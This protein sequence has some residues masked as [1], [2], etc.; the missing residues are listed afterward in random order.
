MTNKS[1]QKLVCVPVLITSAINVSAANTVLTDATVRLDL[2][3]KSI[4]QWRSTP[5]VSHVIVCDGS[6][7][8]FNP[9][10]SNLTSTQGRVGCEVLAFTNDI[11]GVKA[12][13]KGYGEGEIVNHALQQSSVLKDSSHF[14]KCTGKLWIE[15]FSIC[16]KGFNG[17]AS[18]DFRGNFKP[19]QID[20]RFYIVNKKFFVTNM[21]GLH[22]FVDDGNGFYLEHSFR[23]GLSN[24]KL[25]DYVMHPTP[26]I[27]GV[28]GSMGVRFKPN[29]IKDQLR[30]A[31]SRLIKLARMA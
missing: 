14:A 23:D 22:H 28:S 7:F 9:H 5:G 24:F 20:T 29:W 30:D 19:S 25:S 15:N 11:A 1:A 31:R 18:F 2:T 8:D 27:I 17:L 4:D 26:R 3:L 6:G 12:K 10:I 21:S 13:G 16:L